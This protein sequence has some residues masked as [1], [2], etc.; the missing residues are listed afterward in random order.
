MLFSES[1]LKFSM[2]Q[3]PLINRDLS[4]SNDKNTEGEVP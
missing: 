4:K 1:D 3:D 2:K